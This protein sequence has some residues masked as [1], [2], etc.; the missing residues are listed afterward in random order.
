MI[1]FVMLLCHILF[2]AVH[3]TCNLPV[4]TGAVSAA[5]LLAQEAAAATSA[6]G[7]N[8]TSSTNRRRISTGCAALDALL[9]SGGVAC[10][11]VTEFCRFPGSWSMGFSSRL[12]AR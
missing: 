3:V 6:P 9:G 1:Y 5:D 11:T 8:L 2:W 7:G 12:L 10:G 4:T